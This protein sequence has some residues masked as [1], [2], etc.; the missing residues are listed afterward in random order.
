LT[1]FIDAALHDWAMFITPKELGVILGRHGLRIGEI[2]GLGPR[3]NKPLVLL[4]FIRAN[5]G[6]ISYGELSR[7]LDAGQ[8]KNTSISYMGFATKTEGNR[9]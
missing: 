2:V 8:V 5:R 1:R 6:S 4:N 7:R 9:G 3:L